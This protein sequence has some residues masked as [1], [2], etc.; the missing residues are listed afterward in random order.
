MRDEPLERKAEELLVRR[1]TA[2]GGLCPKLAPTEAGI[3]DRLVVYGGRLWLVELKRPSGRLRAVQRAWH[4]RAARAGVTVVVLYGE[5]GVA[6]W[7]E[8]VGI[9]PVPAPRDGVA[10]DLRSMLGGAAEA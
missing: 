9:P 2:A 1:V 3:P 6:S 10:R 5:D 7:L 4:A 8:S